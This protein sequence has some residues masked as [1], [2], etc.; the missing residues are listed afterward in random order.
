M[1]VCVVWLKTNATSSDWWCVFQL[2]DGRRMLQAVTKWWCV[3]QLGDWRRMLQTVTDDVCF[4]CVTQNKYY[5]QW[6]MMCVSVVWRKT[7][8]T[9]SEWWCVFQLCDRRR[10]LQAM[11]AGDVWPTPL[12][13]DHVWKQRPYRCCHQLQL[14]L[15]WRQV[16]QSRL[17]LP[18]H[19]VWRQQQGTLPN[20]L[21]CW[22]GMPWVIS[23]ITHFVLKI[24]CRT[25]C[26]FVRCFIQK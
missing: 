14:L 22:L 9:S 5:K 26:L 15:S 16:Q 1:C 25:C 2:C 11:V 21:E 13:R 10:M 24:V 20:R 19:T 3:F 18:R 7:N 6:L 17:S 4:S 12:P 23:L 8:A